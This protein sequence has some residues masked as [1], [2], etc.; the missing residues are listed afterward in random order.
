[1]HGAGIDQQVFEFDVA[2]ILVDFDDRPPPQPHRSEHVRLS[3]EV[4][5]FAALR[6]LKRN[7]RHPLDFGHAVDFGIVGAV[8]VALLLTGTEV[9]AAGQLAHEQQIDA[10]EQSGRSGVY[11]AS[12]GYALTGRRLANSSKC[13]RIFRI[14]APGGRRPSGCPTWDANRAQQNRV[15]LLGDA[16][17]LVGQR[18]AGLVDGDPTDQ[19]VFEAE[20]VPILRGDLLQHGN[21]R[22]R[23]LNADASPARTVIFAFMENSFWVNSRQKRSILRRCVP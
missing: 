15:G 8:A 13:L 22:R 6:R 21:R 1:M 12:A 5:F 7:R 19:R 11:C 20:F 10:F 14:L 17:R 23:H 4:G 16:Q 18:R 3:T 2:I 9:D